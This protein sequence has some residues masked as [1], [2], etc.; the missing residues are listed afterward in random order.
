MSYWVSLEYPDGECFD[1]KKK[2]TAGGTYQV[3]GTTET[4]LNVTCNYGR[5][6]GEHLDAD[7]L[8]WLDGK[9]GAETQARLESAVE[10]LGTEQSGDY[11]KST[12]G[13]AGYA[14]SILLRWAKEFPH[15][16]WRVN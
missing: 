15:G 6:Y 3:G 2:I 9:N 1:S 16:I 12:P 14:L 8:S 7:R 4:T 10:A 5:H 11:W 13:N